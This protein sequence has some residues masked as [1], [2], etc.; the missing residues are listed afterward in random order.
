MPAKIA[1]ISPANLRRISSNKNQL[2]TLYLRPSEWLQT[3]RPPMNAKTVR[4]MIVDDDQDLAESLADLL[5]VFGYEVTL[6][7][8]GRDALQRAQ[9][10]D[11][12]ITFMD[13]RMPV[14]N[15]VD[16]CLAIKQI[17]PQARIVMMT[18]F[19]EPILAKA[20]AAGAEGPLQKPFSPEDM[21]H[22]VETVR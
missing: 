5:K 14:M 11:F 19:K 6:A 2:P 22:V 3:R 9:M 18:G 10:S 7:A 1:P 4:I 21:L 17:K 16:S 12:D 13:V 20:T 8:N 15:G